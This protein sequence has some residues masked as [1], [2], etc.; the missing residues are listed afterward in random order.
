MVEAAV[1]DSLTLRPCA[2]LWISEIV[3]IS[4]PVAA[5]PRYAVLSG[6]RIIFPLLDPNIKS[7]VNAVIS[8]RINYI[9]TCCFFRTINKRS[10]LKNNLIPC[11]FF[12]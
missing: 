5:E 2:I 8:K 10:V 7:L 9:I 6:L 3:A 12:Y 1:T 4:L 11:I